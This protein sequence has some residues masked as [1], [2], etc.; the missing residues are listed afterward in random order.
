[1]TDNVDVTPGSGATIATDD[2]SGVQF[3]KVKLDM[4]ADG[5]SSPL[6]VGQQ[7]K[8]ASLPVAIASDDVTLALFGPVTETAPATDTASS[9]LNG[10][11]QRVAQRLSSMIA[12]LPTALG[13]GGGLKVDGSGTALPVSGTVAGSGNFASTVADGANVTLGAK[14]DAKSAATDTTAI[15]VVSILKQL[16]AYLGGTLTVGSH[17]VTNA[18]TF[19]VQEADGANVTLGAKADAKSSATD[20]TPISVV[21]ILKQLSAYLGGTL[22]VGSHAVTNAGTFAVQE[23]D[24]ANTTLGAKADAKSTATDT[25]PITAMSV[26]KQISASVQSLVTGITVG[27]QA[28]SSRV[29]FTRPSDT[30]AYAANDIVGITGGGTAGIDFNLGAPSGKDI[31]ITSASIERDQSALV[32]GEANYVLHLYNVTPPSASADNSA[33]DLPSG[34]R[35][36]YLGS[37]NLGTPVDLGSTLYNRTD[38][39]NAHVTLSGTHIFG[40]LVTVG[41]YTP[42]SADVYTVTLHAMAP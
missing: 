12:L 10:R 25:T 32:S 13:A 1:M 21:S 3:Q 40:Y 33:F 11:L 36:S 18:G 17:A 42:V 24:G 23:A 15:S 31:I 22:T 14:A 2:V 41:A 19:A 30:T 16:S 4:G 34:D 37:I 39:I 29:Q 9:G 8:A 27:S 26:W 28:Y 38:G 5:A 7:A 20:T 6:G 35:A